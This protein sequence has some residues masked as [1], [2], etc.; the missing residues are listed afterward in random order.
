MFNEQTCNVCTIVTYLYT[1][2]RERRF[3]AD[4][5]QKMYVQTTIFQNQVYWVNQKCDTYASGN[6][7]LLKLRNRASDLSTVKSSSSSDQSSPLTVDIVQNATMA[8]KSVNPHCFDI[9]LVLDSVFG[10]PNQ[11]FKMIIC[12]HFQLLCYRSNVASPFY[13]TD[14]FFQDCCKF[15]SNLRHF[16]INLYL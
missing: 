1:M 16:G 6:P 5:N 15:V 14:I 11:N 8:T 10:I 7:V 4:N 3:C 9:I 12:A 13:K 2:F